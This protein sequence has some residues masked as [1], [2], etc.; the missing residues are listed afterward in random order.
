MKMTQNFVKKCITKTGTG[1]EK[2]EQTLKQ[3]D[4]LC[5]VIQRYQQSDTICMEKQL[6]KM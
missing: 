1:T 4:N 3:Q 6:L 5:T 2:A